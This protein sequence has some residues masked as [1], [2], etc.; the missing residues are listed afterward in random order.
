[1]FLSQQDMET[2]ANNSAKSVNDAINLQA[3]IKALKD[4]TDYLSI[5]DI[6]KMT[7][8]IESA[9]TKLYIKEDTSL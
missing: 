9:K 5:E 7:S 8:L 3:S 4:D 6:E 2:L 1:M